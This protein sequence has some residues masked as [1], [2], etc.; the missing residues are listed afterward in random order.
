M[1]NENNTHLIPLKTYT[2][3][4]LPTLSTAQKNQALLK[5]LPMRW[6]KKAAVV[7]CVGII[8]L[9]SF[10]APFTNTA[11]ASEKAYSTYSAD[12]QTPLSVA[13]ALEQ[14]KTADIE[15]R[16]HY[17]GSGAGPHY[18]AYITEQEVFSFIRAMLE[19]AG[20]DFSTTPP[21]YSIEVDEWWGPLGKPLGLDLY[22]DEK[23]VAVSFIGEK[24]RSIVTSSRQIVESFMEQFGLTTGVFRNLGESAFDDLTERNKWME[25]LWE[26]HGDGDDGN[27]QKK[28]A[29]SDEFRDDPI[30][31]EKAYEAMRD[32]VFAE[33]ESDY[34]KILIEN[35]TTLTQTFIDRLEGDGILNS[36]QV[37]IPT[38]SGIT[39]TLN[40]K[41]LS[42]DVPPMIVDG[43]T[44]VPL[45]V[46]F[47]ALGMTVEW[48]DNWISAD[49]A[50]TSISLNIGNPQMTVHGELGTKTIELD[51]PPRIINGRT[52]VPL[53]AIAE[54]T[55]ANVEWDATTRTVRISGFD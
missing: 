45:R 14:L 6:Q 32:R 17:G 31:G 29:L 44:L 11:Y 25:L 37:N 1:K 2:A 4:N 3:P 33:N 15:I 30:F 35:L 48:D 38:G 20:L 47:E 16:A 54:A 10:S 46:I 53:R 50:G 39:V 28:W 43:R 34:R 12:I 42:F 41:Q 52:M 19:E 5:K 13:E 7:A 55:G 36:S 26:E 27:W 22:D 24:G 8:G 9:S 49:S 40:G 21:D 51:V 18:V 23:N